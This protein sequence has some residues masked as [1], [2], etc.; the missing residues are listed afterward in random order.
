MVTR[1]LA[2]YIQL[3]IE[4]E[5]HISGVFRPDSN[6]KNFKIGTSGPE[7]GLPGPISAGLSSGELF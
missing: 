6:R 3:E 2:A 7:V 5:D 4:F 1:T